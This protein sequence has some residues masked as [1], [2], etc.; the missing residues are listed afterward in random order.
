[1]ISNERHW[2]SLTQRQPYW[3][4][5]AQ[6]QPRPFVPP[7]PFVRE[8]T[9]Q[10]AGLQIERK[11]FLVMLKENARGRFLRI[12]EETDSHSSSIIIPAT[13]LHDFQKLLE[14]MVKAADEISAKVQPPP[15]CTLERA[16]V[17]TDAFAP[18]AR[19]IKLEQ[20]APHL[21]SNSSVAPKRGPG[22]PKKILSTGTVESPKTK[23]HKMSA[24]ARAKIAA[25]AKARWAKAK[26]AGKT[27]L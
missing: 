16:T 7:R 25:A 20:E 6:R 26:A 10:S 9:L 24:S 8:D 11:Y 27:S 2:S 17:K 5:V 22:R 23:R 4:S 21:N 13:G 15:V 3:E 12:A 19:I 14:E 1:M 18:Q